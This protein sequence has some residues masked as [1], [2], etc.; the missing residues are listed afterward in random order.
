MTVT[1]V[2]PDLRL[3]LAPNPSPMTG[4]GTNTYLVGQGEVT[5]IDPGPALPAHQAA[6]VAALAP[7]ERVT[8][9]LVTHAHLDHSAGARGLSLATG[10]PVMGFGPAGSGISQS[11]A[12]RF[13]MAP[14]EG[15]EGVD[16]AYHPDRRLADG[17]TVVLG[18]QS[19]TALHTPGHMGCHMSFAWND[20]LF[21]GDHVMGWST[22]LISPP[23]G[24]MSAY[25]GSLERLSRQSW[26]SFL[27]GHGPVVT[28]PSA[29]LAALIAHRRMREAAILAE[30]ARGPA[31]PE[32]LAERLYRG[33]PAALLPAATRN[34]LAHLIDLEDRLLVSPSSANATSGPFHLT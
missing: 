28:D 6:I 8:A 30:L 31:S 12:R 29:R 23:E 5:V 24:D 27:P 16:E 4:P 26:Q 13:A 17:E 21:T 32:K 11:M 22:S 15:T 33:T 20:H 18:D 1:Q 3:V 25:L 34:V 2:L 14:G 10:A 9:I 7:G 19:L